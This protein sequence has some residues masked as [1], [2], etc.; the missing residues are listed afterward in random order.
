MPDQPRFTRSTV[1]WLLEVVLATFAR[2]L[3]RV[4]SNGAGNLPEGGAI[5]ASNHLSYV[6]PLVLQLTCQ[7][8]LRFVGF[9]GLE[10]RHWFFRLV[11]KLSGAIA[12]SGDDA[13]GA[14][15][16]IVEHLKLGELVV[17]FVEGSISRTGQLM[18]F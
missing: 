11:F 9:S 8:P 1:P 15:R 7:R 14:T 18:K 2:L 5:V 12:I 16:S 3:Y 13:L 6:D 17:I 4:Q 10:K